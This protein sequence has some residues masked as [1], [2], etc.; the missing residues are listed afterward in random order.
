[1]GEKKSW[2]SECVGHPSKNAESVLP[3]LWVSLNG[4]CDTTSTRG[5]GSDG[6]RA[7]ELDIGL[8]SG[9]RS[10]R[11]RAECP[12]IQPQDHGH[13]DVQHGRLDERDAEYAERGHPRHEI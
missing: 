5:R 7:G 13:R 3:L 10:N 12:K 8:G 6:C 2:A 4:L 9:V 1:M 11:E